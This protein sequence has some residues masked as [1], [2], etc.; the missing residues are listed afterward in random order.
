MLNGDS[1]YNGSNTYGG[2]SVTGADKPA[3]RALLW[4]VFPVSV[5][6]PYAL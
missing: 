5:W 1:G 3:S 6:L 4:W 2:S